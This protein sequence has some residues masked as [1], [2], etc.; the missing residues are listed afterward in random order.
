MGNYSCRTSASSLHVFWARCSRSG[1]GAGASCGVGMAWMRGER[2]SLW[3]VWCCH[4]PAVGSGEVWR[5]P[6]PGEERTS[7]GVRYLQMGHLR[8]KSL[9]PEKSVY[10]D[11][12]SCTGS[13]WELCHAGV[14]TQFKSPGRG[15]RHT[16]VTPTSG[17]WWAE[18]VLGTQ[19]GFVLFFPAF[20]LLANIWKQN[21]A[22]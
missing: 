1:I 19:R 7:W 12:K 22:G 11:G 3:P 9:F 8:S 15:R 13:L 17:V 10:T 5:E 4:Q 18:G 21:F 2:C 6:C 14:L 16:D 20:A